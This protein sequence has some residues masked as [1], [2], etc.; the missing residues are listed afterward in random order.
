MSPIFAKWRKTADWTFFA[1][2]DGWER[3]EFDRSMFP[4][5]EV[6]AAVSEDIFALP[7]PWLRGGL[8]D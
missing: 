8:N 1:N 2:Q 6:L 7:T 5:R 3:V 4:G